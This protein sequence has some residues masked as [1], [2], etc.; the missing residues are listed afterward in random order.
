MILTANPD[1]VKLFPRAT[2]RGLVID[3]RCTCRHFRSLH[4]GAYPAAGHGRCNLQ[5]C[6]CEKFTWHHNVYANAK[7]ETGEKKH[8]Q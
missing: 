3:E 1:V 6:R 8:G 5:N 7:H 4:S 2:V